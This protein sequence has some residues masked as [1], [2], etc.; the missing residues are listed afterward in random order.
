MFYCYCTQDERQV[1]GTYEFE[2]WKDHMLVIIMARRNVIVVRILYGLVIIL[3]TFVEC[4]IDRDFPRVL[5]GL[6]KIVTEM[7]Q[8]SLLRQVQLL[9]K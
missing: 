3:H 7:G 1:N 6:F 4:P 9:D 2:G 5:L 8:G